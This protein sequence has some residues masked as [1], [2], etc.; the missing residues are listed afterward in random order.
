MGDRSL[1]PEV[2]T[3][4]ETHAAF[5]LRPTGDGRSRW[6]RPD[7]LSNPD[8]VK[9]ALKGCLAA[10]LCY[11]FYTAVNW[12]G[13]STAVVTCVLTALTTIGAS[14]QKQTLR[15]AGAIA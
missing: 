3:D 8:H 4:P 9:F 6:F 2:F 5:A 7:A 11:M 14:R 15:I 1:T 10:T 13:I 12:P